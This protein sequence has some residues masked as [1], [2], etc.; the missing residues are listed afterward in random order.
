M[1]EPLTVYTFVP[2]RHTASHYY[3]IQVPC[4]TAIDLGLPVRVIMDSDSAAIDPEQRVRQM[5]ES[6]VM[7]YYQPMGEHVVHNTRLAKSFVP[8][9]RDGEWKWPPVLVVDSDDNIFNVN[10]HNIAFRSLG[11]RDPEGRDIPPGNMLGEVVEGEKRV[12]WHDS[13]CTRESCGGTKEK[14]CERRIDFARNRA[15]IA[16]YRALCDLSDAVTCTTPHVARCVENDTSARRRKVFPNLVRFDHYPQV[17]LRRDESKVKV[18]WQGG[19]SH[20]EDWWPLRESIAEATRR[21]PEIHWV[22]WGVMYPWIMDVIPADRLTFV[23]WCPYQEYKLRM[24]TMGHDINLA[25]LS[26]SRFNECRSAIKVYE[27]AVLADP[28]PTLAQNF[29]PYRDEM[30]D[31]E[32]AMLF[33]TPEEFVTKLGGLVE[34][35]KLRQTIGANCKQWL[36]ENRDAFKRVPEWVAFWQYLR[37]EQRR[38][39]PHMPDSQWADFEARM[40]ADEAKAEEEQ[41]GEAA[42]T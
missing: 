22:V 13:E 15:T 1:P 17:N 41:A 7:L 40:L 9:K 2:H 37:A 23:P 14:P 20:H 31:G 27:S 29:G 8:S 33:N 26:P 5:C 11:I 10:P 32:T 39:Q 16:T 34:D 25:P 28:V 35:A 3:R 18:L 42:T 6:D 4:G 21:W 19:S 36:S 30:V 12:L 24:V 38:E